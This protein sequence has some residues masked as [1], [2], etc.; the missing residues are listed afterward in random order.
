MI[1]KI[2]SSVDCSYWFT[3]LEAQLNQ[4]SLKVLEATNKKTLLIALGT[5]VINSP[6]SP[7]FLA[8]QVLLVCTG[9]DQGQVSGSWHQHQHHTT[10][11][12]SCC[13]CKT[14]KTNSLSYVGFFK[15]YLGASH[16][17]KYFGTPLRG[18]GLIHYP[19]S[20]GRP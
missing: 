19:N 20:Y 4:N 9:I 18:S 12:S 10:N 14:V 2:S 3:R 1:H 7:S 16:K 6:L 13:L 15:L 8:R 11:H 17:V 5:K